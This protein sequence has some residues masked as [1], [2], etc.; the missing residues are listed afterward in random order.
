MILCGWPI[1]EPP[2]SREQRIE[3]AEDRGEQAAF[4]AGREARHG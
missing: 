2:V 1:H 3:A 4:D